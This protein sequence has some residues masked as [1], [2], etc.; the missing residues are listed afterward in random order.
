MRQPVRW[1]VAI[2]VAGILTGLAIWNLNLLN[3]I[4]GVLAYDPLLALILAGSFW[5]S[6]LAVLIGANP[7]AVAVSLAAVDILAGLAIAASPW[8]ATVSDWWLLSTRWGSTCSGRFPSPSW[9]RTD[10]R[11][12]TC[13]IWVLPA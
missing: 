10:S 3:G 5:V 11:R 9:V 7:P 8:P 1:A 4:D 6:G 2:A 12:S 13:R